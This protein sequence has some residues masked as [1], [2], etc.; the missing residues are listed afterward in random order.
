MIGNTKINVRDCPKIL[1]VARAVPLIP[2]YFRFERLLSSTV[3]I[4]LRP[5]PFQR[6]NKRTRLTLQPLDVILF[7]FTRDVDLATPRV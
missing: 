5:R 3:T 2:R 4:N 7:I 6:N 1:H